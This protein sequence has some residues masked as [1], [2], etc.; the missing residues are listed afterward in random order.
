[1]QV[2]R[3]VPA[4][5]VVFLTLL[6]LVPIPAFSSATPFD[7]VAP[8]ALGWVMGRVY[9][10]ETGAPLEGVAVAVQ[11]DGQFA[12]DG[13]TISITD[14]SGQYRC[15]AK[16]GRTASKVEFGRLLNTGLIGLLGGG[17]K[18]ETRRIDVSQLNLRATMD[19]YQS[20]EGTVE[21]RDLNAETLTVH[22]EPILLTHESAAESSTVV[23]GWR[24][25]HITEVA[26][27]PAIVRA[28]SRTTITLQ[29]KCPAIQQRR[30]IVVE[31]ESPVFDKVRLLP[32]EDGASSNLLAFCGTVAIRGSTKPCAADVAITA[33]APFDLGVDAWQQTA[34]YVVATAPE[35]E[36]ARL[37]VR[38]NDLARAG[39]NVEAMAVLKELC[40]LPTAI[41]Q[42]YELQAAIAE[43]VHDFETTV[44]ALQRA[45]QLTPQK[46]E[47][48][49]LVLTARYADVLLASGRH[50]TVL[51]E[52][53]PALD[54]V[55]ADD[56]PKRV[57]IRLMAAVGNAY[58]AQG[59]LDQAE[60][61]SKQLARFPGAMVD[62][63]VRE[64]RR[65]LR[66][67]RTEA[68][69]ASEPDS[70]AA[71]A[72]YGR[73]LMDLGRWEEAVE[74]LRKAAALDP[75]L[76][77]VQWDLGYAIL[78][79]TGS[80]SGIAETFDQALASAEQAVQVGKAKQK[81]KDFFA[82]HRLGLLLYRKACQQQSAGEAGAADTMTRGLE[83]LVEAIRCGHAGADVSEGA[84]SYMTGYTSPK[85]VAIAGFAYPEAN[86]D[87]V[88]LNSLGAAAKEPNDYLAHFNVATALIDLGQ[89]DL[90]ADAL[91]KALALKPDF[92][93]AKYASAIVAMKGGNAGQALGLLQE[94]VKSNPRHD[95]A[96]RALAKLYTEQGDVA[97]AA[98]CLAAHEKYRNPAR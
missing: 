4:L 74:K 10:A 72:D 55:K 71:W 80:S 8:T 35:M 24:A 13:R 21:A 65:S 93:E 45:L 58:V 53:V 42:D 98:A 5:L 51:Q 73:V 22:I 97:A 32:K 27:K 60:A 34:L 63:R 52:I 33:A 56:R 1:M 64:F 29:L 85:V 66:L 28:G 40:A 18:K 41:A 62:E 49:R 19:G 96:T 84:Y 82:W 79:M 38:A 15:S 94:V 3:A 50:S 2:S 37:R 23:R 12:G 7:A 48:T 69:I 89:W 26:V 59:Q 90:A 86:A 16:V 68:A 61:I 30:E 78:Q 77:S 46:P 47:F 67:T 31:C 92:L 75:G 6:L 39:N 88:L 54:N 9:D 20:F 43:K 95:E 87:F 76:P 81:T 70:A 36:A 83:A 17:A 11:Q 91:S 57:P 25:V 14:R 44:S